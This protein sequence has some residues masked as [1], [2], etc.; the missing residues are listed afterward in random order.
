LSLC[1]SAEHERRLTGGK[2]RL[3]LSGKWR[4]RMLRQQRKIA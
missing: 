4:E 3:I 2:M 1:G